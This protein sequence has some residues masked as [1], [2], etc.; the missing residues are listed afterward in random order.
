MLSPVPHSLNQCAA[1]VQ[2]IFTQ[3][4]L[5]AGIVIDHPFPPERSHRVHIQ[6]HTVP[7][8][9]SRDRASARS[10]VEIHPAIDGAIGLHPPARPAAASAPLA[11]QPPAPPASAPLDH[12]RPP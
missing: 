7:A 12:P 10:W 3:R 1:S 8:R 6:Q 5:V 9:G 2:R 11:P 4:S